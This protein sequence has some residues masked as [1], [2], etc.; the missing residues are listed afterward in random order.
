MDNIAFDVN[1]E[2]SDILRR[3]QKFEKKIKHFVLMQ[4]SN[5]KN[6]VEDFSNICGLLTISELWQQSLIKVIAH[7][8]G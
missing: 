2:S 4:L 1:C 3:P 5:L 7:H 8:H 6:K